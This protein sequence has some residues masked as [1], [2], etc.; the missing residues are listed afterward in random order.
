MRYAELRF[1]GAKMANLALSGVALRKYR[2]VSQF[3]PEPPA[4]YF[5]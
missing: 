1:F 5:F 2:G 3:D 4:R